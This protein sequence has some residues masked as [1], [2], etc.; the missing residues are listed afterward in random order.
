MEAS[1]YATFCTRLDLEAN[2][3]HGFLTQWCVSA[4]FVNM[5]NDCRCRSIKIKTNISLTSSTGY[6]NSD[7]LPWFK[8]R[9][10]HYFVS[11]KF[12]LSAY[13]S[14]AKATVDP[15]QSSDVHSRLSETTVPGP[16][17]ILWQIEILPKVFNS[18]SQ[19]NEN[20]SKFIH[21]EELCLCF[22]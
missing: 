14:V 21:G 9:Q 15:V 11:I 5:T 18:T 7:H 8:Q 12:C 10:I 16:E 4:V 3:K 17:L 1:I 2:N 19:R 6:E 22:S 13:I 20:S